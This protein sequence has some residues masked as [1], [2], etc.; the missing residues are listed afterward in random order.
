MAGRLPS[1]GPCRESVSPAAPSWGDPRGV[2]RLAGDLPRQRPCRARRRPRSRATRGRD[3]APAPAARSAR[4][5]ARDVQPGRPHRG[6][7]QRRRARL[8]R[9]RD[10]R[11][12]DLRSPGLRGVRARRENGA[13]AA[14]RPRRLPGHAFTAVVAIGFV[15]NFCFYGSI[16]CLAVGLGRLRGLDALDTGLALLPMTVV[17]AAMALLAGRL[18]PRLGEWRVVAAGL[19]SGAVGAT[20]VALNASHANLALLLLCTVPIG[21]RPSRCRP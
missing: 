19:T 7:H 9:G 10:A 20:L 5:A 16:F 14:H 3:D 1:G 11:A 12:R 4:P 2:T 17:T 15:F 21:S 18:V 8:D 13:P 6:V